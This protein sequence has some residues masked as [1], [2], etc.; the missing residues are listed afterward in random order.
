[1]QVFWR[2]VDDDPNQPLPLPQP[3]RAELC[4]VSVGQAQDF[5]ERNDT[6]L[7]IMELGEGEQSASWTSR[8]LGVLERHGPF[9]LAW[10]ESLVRHAEWRASRWEQRE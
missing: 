9:R 7:A 4:G 5:F 8:T 3:E 1:M 6:K 10:L 2:D